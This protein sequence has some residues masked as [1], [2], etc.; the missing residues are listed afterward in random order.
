MEGANLEQKK[1]RSLILNKLRII[2][3]AHSGIE[4]LF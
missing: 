2:F 4:P 1:I 3:V